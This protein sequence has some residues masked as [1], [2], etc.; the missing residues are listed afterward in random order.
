MRKIKEAFPTW[1]IGEESTNALK[2]FYQLKVLAA[3]EPDSF[4]QIK[5]KND[6]GT[7]IVTQLTPFVNENNYKSLERFYVGVYSGLKLTAPIVDLYSEMHT[8]GNLTSA[9]V[10]T[11]AR[12]IW[13]VFSEDWCEIYKAFCL[14]ESDSNS[15]AKTWNE[16]IPDAWKQEVK[17]TVGLISSTSITNRIGTETDVDNNK[18]AFGSTS[19]TP[20]SSAH[21]T[22]KPIYKENDSELSDDSTTEGGVGR[23]YTTEMKGKMTNL[24]FSE[25]DKIDLVNRTLLLHEFNFFMYIM[26][27]ID[28]V[29]TC[30]CF[31]LN[32]DF[33]EGGEF[34]WEIRQ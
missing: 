2:L 23:D 13:T 34:K 25:P 26:K 17:H 3:A 4:W 24:S 19:S 21:Q 18:K 20:E 16:Q 14:Q 22:S 12:D 33:I 11:F 9:D 27:D 29:L 7:E 8:D 31:E 15:A 28:K 30:E 5:H 1:N 32:D 6:A 10:Q